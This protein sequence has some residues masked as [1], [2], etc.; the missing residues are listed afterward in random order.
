MGGSS[1]ST[2]V[3]GSAQAWAQPIASSAANNAQAIQAQNQPRL[4][5]M[6]ETLSGQLPGIMGKIGQNT[7]S[8]LWGQSAGY[9]GD[10]LGGKYMA[11]NPYLDAVL[12]KTRRDVGDSVNSQ[13][14]TSGRYGSGAYM[15]VLSRNLADAENQARMS[16]YNTQMGR[17]DSAAQLAPQVAAAQAGAQYLGYPEMLQMATGAGALPYV[18]SSETANALG[19]LFNGGT[20]TQKTSN[21]IGGILQGVGSIASSA[22]MFSD[23]RLKRDIEKVGEHPDGLGQYEWQYVW[24]GQRH[25]GVMADEVATLR[26]WA[27]GPE[28]AGF[29]TV[30]YGA[31]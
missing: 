28:V 9:L 4:Q 13:F 19:A 8:P 5:Q 3:T 14:E 29:A 11:S 22:A 31:L 25:R 21:G 27:L 20:Q 10:V 24:G 30:N 1:K 17:M 6:S 26:P 18:G 23:R 12:G 15:D 2:S 7:A 16:D